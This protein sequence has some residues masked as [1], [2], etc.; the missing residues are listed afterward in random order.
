MES[1]MCQWLGDSWKLLNLR[2]MQTLKLIRIEYSDFPKFL[3]SKG[4]PNR[5]TSSIGEMQSL[6]EFLTCLLCWLTSAF[7]SV[8][9]G[10]VH[11][12]RTWEKDQE[13]HFPMRYLQVEGER[14]QLKWQ[15]KCLG[16]MRS[17]LQ[18]LLPLLRINKYEIIL[19]ISPHQKIN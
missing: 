6:I 19:I 10:C 11:Q 17:W 16:C 14:V 4:C 9:Q 13:A 8:T 12:E 5:A 2:E 7:D 1:K 3:Y 15:S 18:S